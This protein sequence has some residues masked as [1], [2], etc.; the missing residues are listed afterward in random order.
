MASLLVPINKNPGLRSIGVGEVLRRIMGK[1]VMVAFS[2]DVVRCSSVAQM[3]GRSSGSEGAIHA[4]RRMYVDQTTE[5][6][7]LVDS[8]NT[9]N[10]LNLEAL[11]HN[12]KYICPEIA[13]YVCNCYTIPARLFVIGGLELKSQERT[14]QGYPL[15]MAIYALVVTP[16]LNILLFGIGNKHNRMVAFADDITAAGTIALKQWWDQLM[17]LAHHMA[18]FHNLKSHG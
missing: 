8:A 15:G 13:T 2:E 12:I 16:M 7:V 6:V 10:N 1:V 14:T 17:K 18:I 3:C 11:I 9:F 5:A 4:M